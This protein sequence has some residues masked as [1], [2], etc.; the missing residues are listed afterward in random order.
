MKTYSKLLLAILFFILFVSPV[1][2]EPPE[3]GPYVEYHDN[4][5]K[6][7]EAHFKNGKKDGLV[8]WWYD[9]GQKR[10]ESRYKNDDKDGLE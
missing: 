6:K 4:G 2:G 7:L 1:V 10:K 9:N 5:K 8:T 3:N